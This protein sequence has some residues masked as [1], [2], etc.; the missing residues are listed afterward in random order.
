MKQLKH[1]RN[2]NAH[3]SHGGGGGGGEGLNAEILLAGRYHKQVSFES[4]F[5]EQNSIRISEIGWFQTVPDRWC[6]KAEGTLHEC[7]SA[8]LWDF[9]KLLIQ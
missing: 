4:G 3:I 9:E 8:K 5:K 1:S 6:K 2:I 7:F